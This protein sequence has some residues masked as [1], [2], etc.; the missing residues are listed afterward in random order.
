MTI[1]NNVDKSNK[2]PINLCVVL[3]TNN[4]HTHTH[5]Q[6]HA[7][8]FEHINDKLFFPFQVYRR[9]NYG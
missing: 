9:G 7:L 6:I 5:T 1:T 2:N 3:L 4:T 8:E